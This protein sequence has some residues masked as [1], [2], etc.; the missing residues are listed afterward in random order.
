MNMIRKYDYDAIVIGARC[1][2]A[3]TAMLLARKGAKVLVVDRDPAGSD[4]MSTHALMRG[5]VFQLAKWGL[6]DDVIAAGT[7]P[8]RQTSFYYGSDRVTVDIRPAH[9][10]AAL[11]APRRTVLD[12]TLV[13][14]AQASGAKVRHSTAAAD[15]IR[16]A[17]GAIQGVV[18]WGQDGSTVSLR[19]PLVIGADGRRS[20]TARQVRADVAETAAHTT[21]A[22]YI[23]ADGLPNR[24]YEWFYGPDSGGGIIPTNGRQSVIFFALPPNQA[25]EMRSLSDQRRFSVA[26]GSRL[27][28]LSAA[29]KDAVL[30][31]SSVTFSGALGVRRKPIGQ[32]WA[33]VGDAGYFKDPLTAHGITDA[34]RDA[35]LLSSAI[36]SGRMQDYP[37]ERDALTMDFFRLT[38]RI[39]SFDWSLDELKELHL[40]LNKAMKPTQERCA[41]GL[42]PANVIP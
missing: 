13:A 32:G 5:G 40:D 9:G 18:L 16:S 2:G 12:K 19:T 15:L 42:A 34:L 4:T 35:E 33:L 36:V 41:Q 1:A 31:G 26:V 30:A 20:W 28:S 3:A 8:I 6:L 21:R 39:A 11:Y 10:T 7:P 17:G 27:P 22:T 38:D 25:A 23:Y 14:A 24:G 37:L 29:I